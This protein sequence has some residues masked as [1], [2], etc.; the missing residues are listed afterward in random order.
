MAS[1]DCVIIDNDESLALLSSGIIVTGCIA[2][3]RECD[4]AAEPTT[5]QIAST[6]LA[7]E[8]FF[9]AIE[10][11]DEDAAQL[12]TSEIST[13][14]VAMAADRVNVGNES[15]LAELPSDIGAGLVCHSMVD[16]A[17]RNA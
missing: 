9:F 4:D 14:S 8:T 1:E 10:Q 11:H 5:T 7:E 17:S 16:L 13:G 15:S 12:S 2:Q 3:T 6:F